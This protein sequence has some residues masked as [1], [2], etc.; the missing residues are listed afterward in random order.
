MTAMEPAGATL[1]AVADDMLEENHAPVKL[2]EQELD[3]PP[4]AATVAAQAE[5]RA[6]DLSVRSTEPSFRD[7]MREVAMQTAPLA[8]NAQA[9]GRD[10]FAEADLVN[11][12][13]QP[14]RK[15]KAAS[16]FERITGRARPDAEPA[17]P[18][19]NHNM[20]RAGSL[21][22][23]SF[24]LQSSDHGR[25]RHDSDRLQPAS[26]EDQLDIPAFLRRQAN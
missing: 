12:A 5:T 7:E 24:D 15:R 18:S 25:N 19:R 3:L 9:Q 26:E 16:L 4:I 20:D 11:A 2:V 6:Q 10:P 1:G 21:G 17:A 23:P 13:N 22:G 8:A 14:P